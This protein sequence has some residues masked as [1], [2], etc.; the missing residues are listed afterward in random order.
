MYRHVNAFIGLMCIPL[1]VCFFAMQVVEG[2]A[3][4]FP[5]IGTIVCMAAMLIAKLCFYRCPFCKLRLPWD[6]KIT[7]GRKP[8]CCPCCGNIVSFHDR[9]W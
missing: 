8:Y 5:A 4:V 6:R 7:H 9:N 3:V 2:T 1:I